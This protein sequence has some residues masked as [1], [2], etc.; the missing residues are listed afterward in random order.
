MGLLGRTEHTEAAVLGLVHQLSACLLARL[1]LA[2]VGWVFWLFCGGDSRC[3][4]LEE[5]HWLRPFLELVPSVLARGLTSST[6]SPCFCDGWSMVVARARFL[7]RILL[8]PL[9]NEMN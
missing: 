5:Q 7:G 1:N 8:L 9:I 3:L 2:S 4:W 6:V